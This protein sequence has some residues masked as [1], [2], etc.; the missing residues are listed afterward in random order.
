[1]ITISP[2]VRVKAGVCVRVEQRF[3]VKVA[4]QLKTVGELIMIEG[5]FKWRWTGRRWVAWFPGGS[6][7]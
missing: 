2:I 5:C 1:M 6:R 7:K 3:I 4:P